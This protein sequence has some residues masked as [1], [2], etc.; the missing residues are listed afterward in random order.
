MEYSLSPQRWNITLEVLGASFLFFLDVFG[1]QTL[2]L[3]IKF[4]NCNLLCFLMS[5]S[6]F[7]QPFYSHFN[8]VSQHNMTTC[9]I[10]TFIL[11]KL[12]YL[13]MCA[14]TQKSSETKQMQESQNFLGHFL[15]YF[16]AEWKIALVTA[17]LLK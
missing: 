4:D 1:Y 11:N 2:I 12:Q 14:Q 16:V 9:L 7:K 13:T 10:S 17:K 3:T 15:I 8:T 6:F 5:L